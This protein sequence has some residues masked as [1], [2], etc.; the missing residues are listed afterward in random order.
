MKMV[1]MLIFW[2]M[3]VGVSLGQV[4]KSKADQQREKQ[5]SERAAARKMAAKATSKEMVASDPKLFFDTYIFDKYVFYKGVL[6][7]MLDTRGSVVR[8]VDSN[9]VVIANEPTRIVPSSR[10]ASRGGFMGGETFVDRSFHPVQPVSVLMNTS[11]LVDGQFIECKLVKAGA[12]RPTSFGTPTGETL[13]E[14]QS[15]PPDRQHIPYETF[16]SLWPTRKGADWY[17]SNLPKEKVVPRS[18]GFG[19]N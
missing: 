12:Y 4:T 19:G 2:I 16:L 6:V 13:Q 5:D 1:S 7:E 11:G 17:E 3:V 15:V 10:S 9:R 8:V 18:G 14:F